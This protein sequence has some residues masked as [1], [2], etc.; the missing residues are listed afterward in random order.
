MLIAL[1]QARSM[2]MFATIMAAGADRPLWEI[3]RATS[4]PAAWRHWYDDRVQG[5]ALFQARDD[6]RHDVR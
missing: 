1:E 6:D 2:A 3:H 5:R 4:R